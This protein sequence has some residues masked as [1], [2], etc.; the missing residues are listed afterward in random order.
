MA[1]PKAERARWMAL[2]ELEAEI[3][4]YH[5][6][7]GDL[8]EQHVALTDWLEYDHPTRELRLEHIQFMRQKK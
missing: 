4:T 3:Q 7:E 5:N 8:K 2:F 1:L 6:H